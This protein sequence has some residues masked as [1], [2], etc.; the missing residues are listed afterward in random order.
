M[1]RAS[2]HSPTGERRTARPRPATASGR[3]TTATRSCDDDAIASSD[4]SATLG[5][6]AKT[7]RIQVPPGDCVGAGSAAL[8]M[9]GRQ[10]GTVRVELDRRRGL[11]I[12]LRGPDVLHRPLAG[13]R[14]QTINEEYAVEVVGFVLDAPR[15]Q[16]GSDNL[17]R[18]TVFGEA[19]GDDV[20]P[21]LGVVVEPRDRQAAF[22]AVLFFLV[23]EVQHRIDQ[24]TEHV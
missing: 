19:L 11:A 13:V 24:V 17:Q 5:V 6:P 9:N 7:S 4:G 10:A 22:L 3:V 12:P 15:H 1:P 20:H 21:A 23:R 16:A 2:A 8:E 18:V 14:V